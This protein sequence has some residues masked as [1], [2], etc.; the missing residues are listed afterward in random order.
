M[1]VLIIGATSAIAQ[2][3]AKC[4]AAQGADLFL[5]GRNAEKMS[6]IASDLKVR[7]AH[8]VESYTADLSDLS[9]HQALLDAVLQSMSGLDA[10]LI[11]HG[12]LGDQKQSEADVQDM[13]QEFNTN[14]LS[15]LSLMTLL[16]N[17]FEKQGRGTLAVISSVAGERGRGSNYVYGSAKGAVSLFA[18]GLRNRLSKAGV[19]VVTVK[20]GFVDTPMTAG[21][22]KNPLYASAESV[23]K[24]I[25]AAMLKG[26][27]IVYAPFFWAFIM[28]IIRN[29]PERIFKKLKL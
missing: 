27:D 10:A 3:T 29:I 26:E 4:F 13:L 8:A 23:G 24:R 9:S 7:G 5:V 17:L 11:A 14:G 28:L 19:A 22:K 12:T 16:G 18:Q 6:A 20:P 2:E 21:L 15:Y 1:K 25:H